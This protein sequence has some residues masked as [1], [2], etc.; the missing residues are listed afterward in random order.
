[1]DLNHCNDLHMYFP[2]KA[3]ADPGFSLGG[4]PTLQRVPTYDFA[5]ISRK[6]HEI[7]I[8]WTAGWGGGGALYIPLD[9][10]M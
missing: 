1:M 10:P 7:E 9:P 8:I 3:V 6:L 2:C 5:K 4:A